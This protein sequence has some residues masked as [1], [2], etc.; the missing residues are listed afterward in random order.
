M[1]PIIFKK[2]IDIGPAVF[3]SPI[4]IKIYHLPNNED[5]LESEELRHDEEL[6]E[7]RLEYGAPNEEL[8]PGRLEEGAVHEYP[9]E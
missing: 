9:R 7:D 1:L 6:P 8:L 3:A 5:P 2:N 4:R